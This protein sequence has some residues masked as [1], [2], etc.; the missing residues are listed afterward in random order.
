MNGAVV[1]CGGHSRRMGR[2]KA[3]LP[4]GRERLLQRVVRLVAEGIGP[5][6]I[7]VVA[8][9][10]QELPA[11][12][13]G[14]M[15][16][17]DAE[18]NRGPVQGLAAGMA[19]L[20]DEVELVFVS[21]TDAPF[22]QPAWICRLVEAMGDH[23]IA[24]PHL[25]GFYQP[26]CALYRRATVLPELEALIAANRMRPVFLLER[27]RSR[28]LEEAELRAVD[29]SLGTIRNMNMPQDYARALTDAGFT[30]APAVVRVELFG[31]ARLRAG[32]SQ[33]V[34]EATTLGGALTEA[35]REVPEL[36]GVVL[37]Q[38]RVLP[39]HRVS[40]NGERFLEDPETPLLD[41]DF[42]LLISADVGG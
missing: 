18:E 19:A 34:V 28:V 26:L 7:V 20:P 40:L 6:P 36:E 11:L 41:G 1:L 4:F 23:D 42:L 31:I 14:V 33:V 24:I 12:P 21:P 17:R 5:G 30:R 2:P 37:S 29:P 15:V 3:W 38:G 22:L 16:A 8:A 35:A 32:V 39:A 10:G 9:P 27:L 25:D 13:R